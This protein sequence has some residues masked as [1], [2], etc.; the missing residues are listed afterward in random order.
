MLFP[1]I[2]VCVYVSMLACSLQS[3]WVTLGFPVYLQILPAACE[4]VPSMV[5]VFQL[6]ALPGHSAL[7]WGAFPVFGSGFR[8]VQGRCVEARLFLRSCSVSGQLIH[9]LQNL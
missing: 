7:A 5:L 8:H 3:L 6:I 1:C 4:A 2:C 9:V